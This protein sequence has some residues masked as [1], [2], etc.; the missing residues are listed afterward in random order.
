MKRLVIYTRILLQKLKM[1]IYRR[2]CRGNNN[3]WKNVVYYFLPAHLS[4]LFKNRLCMIFAQA[5]ILHNCPIW[6][7]K[8]KIFLGNL[9][10][11]SNMTYKHFANIS[12][13][14]CCGIS[15]IQ[16][17]LSFLL[18]ISIQECTKKS[19]FFVYLHKKHKYIAKNKWQT[20]RLA[21]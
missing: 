21:I 9:P 8:K 17:D 7:L 2:F 18:K 10:I 15:Y 20:A 16:V 1:V 6:M 14:Q 13:T 3:I 19:K 5:Q 4:T 12:R 11:A